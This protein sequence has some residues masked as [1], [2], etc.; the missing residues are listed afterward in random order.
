[1]VNGTSFCWR[2]LKLINLISNLDEDAKLEQL[3]AFNQVVAWF[4]R[5][6]LE[7]LGHKC[8]FVKDHNNT[9]PLADHSIII[10]AIATTKM[11]SK[12]VYYNAVRKA[13]TG[14]IT[15]YLDS[16]FHGWDKLYNSVF[17]VTAPLPS[18]SK[19]F[20]YAGWGADPTYCYPDQDEKTVFLDRHQ[21][22]S[23][24]GQNQA[25]IWKTYQEVLPATGLKILHA[26]RWM[27]WF[28][29]Q[30]QFF[31]KAHYY[32]CTQ[33]GESGLTRIEA[34]TCGALLVVPK[35]LYRP[36]TMGSLEHIIWETKE[37]LIAALK[38]ETNPKEI[39]EKAKKH[40]WNL[41]AQRIINRISE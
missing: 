32:C 19:K 31:R 1:M 18:S 29:I 12:P 13:T 35:L 17:T 27:K 28:E 40:S 15:L 38:L 30:S 2:Q 4:L 22:L 34:A 8:R 3:Y 39:S 25:Q 10:S 11:R 6:A 21:N 20:I 16:D 26:T 7:K 5:D 14:K 23:S 33:L 24:H 41:V 9:I 36:R 37:D